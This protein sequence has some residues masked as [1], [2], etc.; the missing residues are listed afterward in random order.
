M[1]NAGHTAESF[2][3]KITKAWKLWKKLFTFTMFNEKKETSLLYILY[4]R[5]VFCA[6]NSMCRLKWN[7]R[8]P[9]SRSFVYFFFYSESNNSPCFFNNITMHS[10]TWNKSRIEVPC[11]NDGENQ[12]VNKSPCNEHEQFTNWAIL[13]SIFMLGKICWNTTHNTRQT[14]HRFDMRQA[15][16][17]CVFFWHS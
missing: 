3:Q 4:N 12:L 13:F 8:A 7:K 11:V 9:F 5:G 17:R 1:Y 10:D 15:E 2:W 14:L 6:L 16:S